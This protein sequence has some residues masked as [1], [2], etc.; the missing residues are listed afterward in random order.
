M[1]YSTKHARRAGIAFGLI[2]G[3]PFVPFNLLLGLAI[4]ISVGVF[5]GFLV[6]WHLRGKERVWATLREPYDA[7]GIVHHAP[8]SCAIG[9]GYMV[10]TKNRLVWI[11][12]AERDRHKRIEIA[13]S[14][15]TQ[16]RKATGFYIDL[17]I[18]VRTGESIEFFT[19]D[20]KQ[21]IECLAPPLPEA[22]AR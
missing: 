9:P 1:R 4:G 13:R 11:P 19:R 16:A 8:A 21:W 12:M 7:E 2:G 14:A 5:V 18:A 15:I 17:Y 3:L 22:S 10:L 20:H 6:L